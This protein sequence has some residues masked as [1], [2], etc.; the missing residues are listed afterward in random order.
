VTPSSPRRDRGDAARWTEDR[1]QRRTGLQGPS[2]DHST[3]STRSILAWSCSIADPPKGAEL[4]AAKWAT[5]RK[6]PQIEFKPDWTKQ[7]KAGSGSA[8]WCSLAPVFRPTSPT[9]ARRSAFRSGSPA[10]AAQARRFNHP[11]MSAR[12]MLAS[13]SVGQSPAV[14]DRERPRLAGRRLP[15]SRMRRRNQNGRRLGRRPSR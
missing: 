10:T 6:V 9:R 5:N 15:R 2:L 12:A 1:S 14:R 7:A 11:S 4:I 13:R 3:R 8:L